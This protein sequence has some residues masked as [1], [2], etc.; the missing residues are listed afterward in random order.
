MSTSAAPAGDLRPPV[1]GADHQRGS[2]AAAVT[3][4]EYGDYQ[5]PHCAHA[6]PIVQEMRRRMGERLRVVY[7]HFPLADMHPQA[8]HAAEAAESV[9]AHGG[10]DAFWAMHDRL[11]VHAQDSRAALSDR[12]LL[13][14]AAAVGVD[15]TLVARDL[16]EGV[17]EA[18]VR[19][20]F[21][22]GVR[23]GVTG[24]PTFFVNGARLDVR[25]TDPDAFLAALGWEAALGA[26]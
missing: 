20:G 12:E 7:R 18:R 26:P 6:H 16:E 5:C 4:V 10:A 21:M 13:R 23:S 9:G 2:S 24:T 1:T 8:E 25:W 17:H 11:Y 22:S 19:A 3:L 15:P 14:H